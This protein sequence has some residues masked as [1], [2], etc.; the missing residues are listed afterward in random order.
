MLMVALLSLT[1]YT[2]L[3]IAYK[4]KATA[5]RAVNSSREVLG[6]M[7]A[8]VR[9]IQGAQLPPQNIE[10][11]QFGVSC[12]GDFEATH[13]SMA[14][15]DADTVDF[16]TLGNDSYNDAGPFAEGIRHVI[17][18]VR[19]DLDTPTLVR[20]VIRN[21]LAT[22][23]QTPDE[24]PLCA[25]VRS[26]SIKWWDGATWQQSWDSEAV[27]SYIPLMAQIDLVV[28]ASKDKLN[29]RDTSGDYHLTRTIMLPMS[30]PFQ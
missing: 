21:V 13:D 12:T 26:F 19:Q 23:Q 29:G 25:N 30:R 4:S 18:T 6:A 2:C 14:G 3:N 1:L 11:Q 27:S 15:G 8:V 16:F 5:E 17:L 22:N 28:A 24:E 9:D 20:Q 10:Y 7:D